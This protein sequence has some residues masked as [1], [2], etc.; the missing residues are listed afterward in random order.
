M[1]CFIRGSILTRCKRLH[2]TSY[3]WPGARVFDVQVENT[4]VADLDLFVMGNYGNKVALQRRV[5]VVVT[6]SNLTIQ[7][8]ENV[9]AIENPKLSAIVVTLAP[10]LPPTLPPTLAPTAVPTPIAA[11]PAF[12]PILINCGGGQH[13]DSLRR[14]WMADKFW[15]GG[16]GSFTTTKE[17][18]ET[19]EDSLYQTY[20]YGG[21]RY[22]IPV[23]KGLYEVVLHFAET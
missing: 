16:L 4:L 2:C 17:V 13:I 11:V 14:V 23:R 1:C 8:L 6:D 7:L 10:P 15:T 9:P 5:T 22:D 19:D 20:R 3:T 18:G 21:V 12:Q